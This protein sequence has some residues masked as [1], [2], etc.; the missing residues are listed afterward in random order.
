[1]KEKKV[2]NE[3]RKHM[4][5]NIR[6]MKIKY[7][8]QVT[9][10]VSCGVKDKEIRSVISN[11]QTKIE[12][13][14]NYLLKNRGKIIEILKLLFSENIPIS[15]NFYR[16]LSDI[17]YYLGFKPIANKLTGHLWIEAYKLLPKR[18]ALE[19]LQLLVE[20]ESIDIFPRIRSLPIFLSEVEIS[21]DFASSWF[22]SMAEK[23]G[24]DLAGGNFFKAVNE[25]AFNF[26]QSGLK[27]FEQYVSEGLDNLRLNLSAI[28]LG[29]LRASSEKRLIQKEIIEGWE[30]KLINSPQTESRLC[31]HKSWITSFWRGIISIEQLESKLAKMM[32]GTQEEIDE[33]FYV[34][35][36]CLLNQLT[37]E[38]FVKFSMQWFNKNASGKIPPLAKYC[39]VNSMLRLCDVREAKSRLINISDANKLIIKVQPI[40]QENN[41]TWSDIEYY[42]ID[43]L[44]EDKKSF[45]DILNLLN[46]ANP[47]T[48]FKKFR[49][50]EF[51]Y[52]T[53]KLSKSDA[54]WLITNLIFSQDAKKRKLGN[55]LFQ[56]IKINQFSSEIVEKTDETQMSI[57]L[58]EFIRRPFLGAEV[59]RFLIML[60][61][62]YRICSTKMQEEYKREMVM[63]AINYPGECLENWKKMRNP[64]KLL[65]SVIE[66]AEKYF[67]NLKKTRNSPANSFS[68]PELNQSA[69]KGYREYSRKI[70]EDAHKTSILSRLAKHIDIMYGDQWSIMA[71]GKLGDPTPFKEVS[72]SI[73][74]PRLEEIDPEGM[75]LRK[76]QAN[77]QIKEAE[78]G[79]TNK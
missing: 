73:E 23:I 8:T 56:K 13:E 74:A 60:E 16:K 10:L 29:A 47:E 4:K 48:L 78:K 37:S 49:S 66:S 64:S 72:H 54:S 52:L 70:S 12:K 6:Q 18:N 15:S 7:I 62:R 28:I 77:T 3:I 59:S 65:K 69:K 44:H 34:L 40:P 2:V 43:R 53:S 75:V 46:E 68:F 33:A 21:S 63:Q 25:Y 24:A 39:V 11:S 22:F 31:Y 32:E 1:M 41:G 20:D 67:E 14:I 30:E 58:W 9:E 35:Y 42:L 19:L 79:R 76:V 5:K 71:Q 55:I 50:N 27:V 17:E 26:P 45:A 61:P 51:D 38:V 36:K 57:V